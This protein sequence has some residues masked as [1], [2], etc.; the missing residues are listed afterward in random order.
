MSIL[1][2]GAAHASAAPACTSPP[3]S[4][5]KYKPATD[6]K[7]TT[8]TAYLDAEGNERPLSDLRGPGLVINFW[9]TW[10]AP[11]VKEMPALDRLA[12]TAGERGLRVLALSADREGAPVVRQFYEKNGV[13]NLQI[14][15]DKMGRV[16]RATGIDGLPTT[17]LYDAKGREVGRVVGTAEWD[18]PAVVDFLVTCLAARS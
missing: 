18:D 1:L 11:C 4:L 5:G 16:G 6:A 12:A 10:C 3:A 7:E 17:V 14:A 8:T 13:Q 9:A 15:I 2:S